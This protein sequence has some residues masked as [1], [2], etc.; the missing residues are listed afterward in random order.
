MAK[1]TRGDFLRCAAQALAQQNFPMV[2]KNAAAALAMGAPQAT[3]FLL[4]CDRHELAKIQPAG[5]N[6][7]AAGDVMINFAIKYQVAA[8]YQVS[9]FHE[10]T[11]TYTI[12]SSKMTHPT[13]KNLVAAK[14]GGYRGYIET[15][16]AQ[17][18]E[19]T[20]V[21]LGT[22]DRMV[23]LMEQ[24]VAQSP[25]LAM[26]SLQVSAPPPPQGYHHHHPEQ[27]PLLGQHQHHEEKCWD[28]LPCAIL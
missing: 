24:T 17:C 13:V 20:A 18:N 15:A 5:G 21:D 7:K 27:A 9:G 14:V 19:G 12:I 10:F 28:K 8:S 6:Q 22:A 16:Q 3:Y 1:S 11:S 2:Y 25:A 4:A 23:E 26:Q